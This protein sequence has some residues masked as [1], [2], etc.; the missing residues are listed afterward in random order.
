MQ[1]IELFVIISYSRPL[2]V[3]V[4]MQ[5]LLARWNTSVTEHCLFN[6]KV[7]V[8]IARMDGIKD[9]VNTISDLLTTGRG[10]EKTNEELHVS[11]VYVESNISV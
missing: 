5:D 2:Q 10:F 9:S 1:L 11:P 7:G 4:F 3:L 6:E 8:L